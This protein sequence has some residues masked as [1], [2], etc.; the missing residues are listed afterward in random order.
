MR[1]RGDVAMPKE[2]LAMMGHPTGPPRRPLPRAT[3]EDKKELKKVLSDL[4]LM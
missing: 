2:A 4:R 3:E 1:R